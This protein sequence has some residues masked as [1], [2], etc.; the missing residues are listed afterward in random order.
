MAAETGIDENK[1]NKC[2]E[3]KK[4]KDEVA[5]DAAAAAKAGISGTPGFVVGKLEKDGSVEG[6]L[7]KGAQAF[8]VFQ[9]AI[10]QL[11]E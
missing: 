11:L 1:F 10:E 7:L 2:L 5:Q 4:F 6:K 8:S 3:E 9:A